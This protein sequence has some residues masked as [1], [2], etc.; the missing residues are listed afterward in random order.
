MV[1]TAFAARHFEVRDK[2]METSTVEVVRIYN[3]ASETGIF[4]T[5]ALWIGLSIYGFFQ[6]QYKTSFGLICIGQVL[7]L[8]ML[9]GHLSVSTLFS[10]PD[11]YEFLS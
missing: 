4:L 1:A 6:T 10:S 7:S 3:Y 8:I 2:N 5:T 11:V 9:I